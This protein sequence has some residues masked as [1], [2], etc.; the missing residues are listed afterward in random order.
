MTP[1]E[2]LAREA[3]RLERA[4]YNHPL[5]QPPDTHPDTATEQAARRATLLREFNDPRHL[6]AVS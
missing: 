5:P 6:K 4:R 3:A 1:G 2:E